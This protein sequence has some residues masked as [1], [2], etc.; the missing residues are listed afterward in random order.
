MGRYTIDDYR[1]GKIIINGEL[2]NKDLII[3]SDRILPNW[4]REH[5]HSLSMADLK[6]V[7]TVKPKVLII[8]TGM[9]GRIKIQDKILQNLESLDIDIIALRTG[10]ACKIYNQ[11][12]AENDIIAALHL[13]C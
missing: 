1:F 12:Q 10:N 13:T 5:G 6:E 3:F 7:I 8:G 9:Y 11:K 2:Y 4:W